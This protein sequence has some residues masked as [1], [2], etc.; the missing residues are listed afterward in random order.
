MSDL[1]CKI[2][3]NTNMEYSELFEIIML[4]I[5]GK[6]EARTYIESSWCEMSI[7]K[8]KEYNSLENCM[9]FVFWKFYIDV[10]PLNTDEE[11]YK[12]E[13]YNLVSFL[14]KRFNYVVVS[15]DFED[16]FIN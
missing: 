2:F 12:N 15:C 7:Q 5:N 8:N 6:K 4:Y 13:L 9:D 10:E 3:L 1:F 16:E 14:K 11:T